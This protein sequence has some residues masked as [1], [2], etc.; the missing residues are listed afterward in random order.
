V[1]IARFVAFCCAFH[2]SIIRAVQLVSFGSLARLR[3][4]PRFGIHT[5]RERIAGL[6]A[7][8]EPAPDL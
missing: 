2:S 4:A 8:D 7:L 1:R 6:I 3:R 5:F